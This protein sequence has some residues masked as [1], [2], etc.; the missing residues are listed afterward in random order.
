MLAGVHRAPALR[1]AGA[2]SSPRGGD[3]LW[4]V[5]G[6]L[7][8]GYREHDARGVHLACLGTVTGQAAT[9]E[10]VCVLRG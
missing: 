8:V 5:G 6:D 9:P 2:L 10:A 3:F 4:L 7:A 1:D